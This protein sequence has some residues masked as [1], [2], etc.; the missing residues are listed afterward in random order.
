MLQL[1]LSSFCLPGLVQPTQ[2]QHTPQAAVQS[3]KV[4]IAPPHTSNLTHLAMSV[5]SLSS[6]KSSDSSSQ[7]S[8]NS[9]G[10]AA[11]SV[12]RSSDMD[13]CDGTDYKKNGMNTHELQDKPSD[14]LS[15]ISSD[16]SKEKGP[17]YSTTPC[18]DDIS[19]RCWVNTIR[20]DSI[21]YDKP[22]STLPGP[23]DQIFNWQLGVTLYKNSLSP[24]KIGGQTTH[25]GIHTSQKD[26][27]AGLFAIDESTYRLAVS[28][29]ARVNRVHEDWVNSINAAGNNTEVDMDVL[30][31]AKTLLTQLYQPLGGEHTVH[32]FG[33]LV[34]TFEAKAQ[35]YISELRVK[36]GL[37]PDFRET[38]RVA[39]QWFEPDAPRNP[40]ESEEGGGQGL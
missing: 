20:P 10:T 18:I 30:E 24:G 27:S 1:F 12:G 26:Q 7:G 15:Y 5:P 2:G 35:E 29:A 8:H 16:A 34:S 38:R 3:H 23:N 28:P 40:T 32:D 21:L 39:Y 31:E 11:T 6:P 36:K 13:S 17:R 33:N 9:S 25:L 37:S 14:V 22:P 4:D 19:H